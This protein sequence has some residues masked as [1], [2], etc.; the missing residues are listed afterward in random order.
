MILEI[1]FSPVI[2]CLEEKKLCL[3]SIILLKDCIKL[4]NLKSLYIIKCILEWLLFKII[5]IYIA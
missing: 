2:L 3:S 4:I 1:L 5:I